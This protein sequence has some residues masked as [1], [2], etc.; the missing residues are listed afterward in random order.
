MDLKAMK[1]AMEQLKV[2]KAEIA[3]LQ[4]QRED[5]EKCVK[6]AKAAADSAT[7]R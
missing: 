7:A 5:A 2:A 6:D 3:R 1:E 4:K